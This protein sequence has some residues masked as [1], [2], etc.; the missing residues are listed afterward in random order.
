M[1]WAP[2]RNSL[3]I[4]NCPLAAILVITDINGLDFLLPSQASNLRGLP[5][6]KTVFAF[7]LYF[8]PF[9]GKQSLALIGLNISRLPTV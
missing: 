2:L 7:H 6:V 9:F 4:W 1:L 5:E 3:H 8:P